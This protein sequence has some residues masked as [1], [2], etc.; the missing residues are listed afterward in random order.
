M[1]RNLIKARLKRGEIIF[2]TMIQEMRTPAIGQ[3][4][5][6]SGFDFFMLD[7]ESGAYDLE[8]ALGILQVG[9]FADMCPLVRVISPEYH[10]IARILD[11]GAMGIMAPRIES[12]AEVCRL[13][14]AA[15]YPPLGKRGFASNGPHLEYELVKLPEVLQAANED[16]LVIAQIELQAAVE[17]IDDLLSVPGVDVALIGPKDLSISLGVPGE[18]NHPSVVAAIERVIAAGNRH[19][20][21]TG[22]HVDSIEG[23]RAWMNKGMRMIMYGSDVSFLANASRAGLQQLRANTSS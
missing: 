7:M 20:V 18:T 14:E 10:L 4:L 17:Q 23:L 16:T 19:G 2:G 21:V 5:R 22:I 8:T 1:H 11:Q 6:Q 9:R 15:K 13:V 3:L 12:R